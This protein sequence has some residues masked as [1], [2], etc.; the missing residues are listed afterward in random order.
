MPL[1]P[2][3]GPVWFV[4]NELLYAIGGAYFVEFGIVSVPRSRLDD[5]G[6]ALAVDDA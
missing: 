5:D 3:E 4:S 1:F 6:L 2:I